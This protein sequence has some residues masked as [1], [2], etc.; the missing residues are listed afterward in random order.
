M[1]SSLFRWGWGAEFRLV[2]NSRPLEM[3]M[4]RAGSLLEGAVQEEEDCWMISG[5]LGL[6]V[7]EVSTKEEAAG[8]A[9]SVMWSTEFVEVWA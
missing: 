7:N 1:E 5:R 3:K 4:S 6:L 2:E 9:F 8:E